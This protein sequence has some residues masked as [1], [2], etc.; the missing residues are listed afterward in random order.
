MVC[1]RAKHLSKIRSGIFLTISYVL[2]FFTNSTTTTTNNNNHKN[3]VFFTL[4]STLPFVPPE[5][6]SCLYVHACVRVCVSNSDTHFVIN[7]QLHAFSPKALDMGVGENNKH[8]DM[9][10]TS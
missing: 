10:I 1:S 2:A 4:L 6:S 5:L 8:T 9:I 3:R 7:L